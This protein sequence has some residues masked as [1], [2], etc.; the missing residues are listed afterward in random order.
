MAGQSNEESEI[1]ALIDDLAQRTRAKDVNGVISLYA[2]EK[3]QFLL[4]P[5]LKY[6]GANALKSEDLREWF[7]S[8]EGPI[9]F[10]IH[11]LEV[12]TGGQ[13]AFCHALNRLSGTKTDGTR[14][15]LWLRWTV[16]FRKI[17]GKWKITHEHE[18]VPFYMDGS[19]KAALDLEP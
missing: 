8:F 15:D 1:R 3:V 17:A 6:S 9:G 12:A 7:S 14:T 11:D 2:E 10:E 4:A 19:S 13:V 18:S 16:C 5:P